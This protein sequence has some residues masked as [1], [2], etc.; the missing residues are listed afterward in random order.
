MEKDKEWNVTPPVPV[1]GEEV[2]LSRVM[3][4]CVRSRAPPLHSTSFRHIVLCS[5]RDESP[6]SYDRAGGQGL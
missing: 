5:L 1:P 2:M 4:A 6:K 3:R